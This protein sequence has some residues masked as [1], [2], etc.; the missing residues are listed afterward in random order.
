MIS[1]GRS[2]FLWT[3]LAPAL[4]APPPARHTEITVQAGE[5]MAVPGDNI[6]KTRGPATPSAGPFLW[7]VAR[8][9]LRKEVFI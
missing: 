4:T 3:G 5:P 1:M 8:Q 9:G 6:T 7:I 2:C